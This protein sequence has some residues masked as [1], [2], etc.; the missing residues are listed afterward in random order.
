MS[1]NPTELDDTS[2]EQLTGRP[3]SAGSN[4]EDE[5]LRFERQLS[6]INDDEKKNLTN[7]QPIVWDDPFEA[8]VMNEQT[9]RIGISTENYPASPTSRCMR[10]RAFLEEKKNDRFVLASRMS[11]LRTRAQSP[12]RPGKLRE[13]E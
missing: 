6:T 11:I 8:L 1:L 2:P 13:R 5:E 10:R 9:G 3:L 7:S 12:K 4:H